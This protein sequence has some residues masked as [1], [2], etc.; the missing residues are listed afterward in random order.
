V[1]DL[2]IVVASH[3]TV[4]VRYKDS[5]KEAETLII[6]TVAK[7]ATGWRISD[8]SYANQGNKTLRKLLSQPLKRVSGR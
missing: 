2:R 5:V 6:Y 1:T 7:Q 8:V 4:E 3:N